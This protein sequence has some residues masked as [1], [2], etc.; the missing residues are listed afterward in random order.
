MIRS[1]RLAVLVILLHTAEA[2][3]TTI[4]LKLAPVCAAGTVHHRQKE[5]VA[6]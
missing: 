1:A 3:L 5:L 6:L 4:T 2:T